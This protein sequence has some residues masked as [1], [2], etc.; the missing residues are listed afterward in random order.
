MCPNPT[1]RIVFL[2]DT[3]LGFDYPLR[4]RVERRR[5]G[6]D[7]FDNFQRVL[8]HAV[9]SKA[10]LLV[11]GGDLFFRKRVPKRIIDLAHGALFEFAAKGIPV[12]VVPGNH[13]RSELPVSL[14]LSHPNI[15]VFVEPKTE[16]FD[17]G[18][19]RVAVSG[20]P[21]ERYDVRERFTS[22][23]A[24]TRWEKTAAEIRLLCFH[25][26]VEG[27]RV[28]PSNYTFRRGSDV[29]RLDE[30]PD[31]LLAVLAGHIHRRQILRQKVRGTPNNHR[32]EASRKK[33]SGTPV[34]Y[35]G[36]TERTSF[37]EKDEP[38]GFFDLSFRKSAGGEWIL[39]DLEF[40]PLPT[41][42]MVDLYLD[43]RIGPADLVPFFQSEIARIDPNAIV[44]LRCTGQLGGDV[45]RKLSGRLL[46]G[47]FP[48][49]MNYQLSRDLY[50]PQTG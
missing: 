8:D 27:A 47:V 16:V 1:I 2:A 40:V 35:P 28:G 42:P 45:K 33:T 3:H 26:V 11:H 41:R 14:Y 18:G 5:R 46:R 17:I 43:G 6:Q 25:Q 24:A 20:F 36:S 29:I 44:R 22:V 37:A 38:K 10:D 4:P 34:I 7:F 49:T 30:I 19:V 31:G 50:R 9:R 48:D 23:V 13:E 15:H 39:D 32:H 21:F 12:I